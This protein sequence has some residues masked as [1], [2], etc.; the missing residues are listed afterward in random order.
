M[1]LNELFHA[2][3]EFKNSFETTVKKPKKILG[4]RFEAKATFVI[5]TNA[6]HPI[7]RTFSRSIR[8]KDQA[9]RNM[10][11]EII[12]LQ[13]HSTKELA[14]ISHDSNQNQHLDSITL[15]AG[16]EYR[17]KVTP[18]GQIVSNQF[19]LMSIKDRKCLLKEENILNVVRLLPFDL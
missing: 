7:I 18:S 11:M 14:K 2:S 4:G 16:N 19:K 5:N 9:T 15:R 13:I 12:Q 17:I 6:R 3:N 10:E 8:A 1:D